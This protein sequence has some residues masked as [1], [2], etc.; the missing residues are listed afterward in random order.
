MHQPSAL[1]AAAAVLLS[2]LPSAYAGLYP[3]SSPVLQINGKDFDRLVSRSNYTTVSLISLRNA[4]PHPNPSLSCPLSRRQMLT[5]VPS[6]DTR[7][8]CTMVRPLPEPEAG[9]RE[10]SSK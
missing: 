10:G 8:L 9:L 7:V 3:K 1:S 5:D 4:F 2:A 6:P